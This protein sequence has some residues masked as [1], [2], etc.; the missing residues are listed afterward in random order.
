MKS[1]MIVV[2]VVFAATMFYGLGSIGINQIEKRNTQGLARINGEEINAGKFNQFFSEIVKG[3]EDELTPQAIAFAQN[4]ALNQMIDF[5]L[6]LSEARRRN[7][8]LQDSEISRTVEEI[9]TK[10]KLG[11]E[12]ELDR[13]LRSM[14]SSLDTFK[15]MIREEMLVYKLLSRVRESV[16]LDNNDLREV[17]ARHI[18][19]MV[20]ASAEAK[21]KDEVKVKASKVLALAKAGQ[22]FAKLA[23]TY[24]QDPGSAS[25]GGS[26]GT[27]G[28][29]MM[30]LEFE[31]AAFALR[32][33][34][35]SELVETKYGY[36]IIK[37][38]STKLR[39]S[40]DPSKPLKQALLDDKRETKV[41]ELLDELRKNAKVE[42]EN[43]QLKAFDLRMKGDMKA[44]I[45]T[46]NEAIKD[47]PTDGYL[48]LF[49][50]DTY[51]QQKEMGKAI[52]SYRK[53]VDINAA[54][55][56]F[57]LALGNAYLDGVGTRIG[58]GEVLSQAE[59]RSLAIQNF[60][61]AA[62]VAG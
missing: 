62:T 34:Q 55:P 28:T 27:F 24:S 31:K 37:L 52:V 43:P 51:R 21:I 11:S 50:G 6:L 3:K 59:S 49:L 14:G 39:N 60:R 25:K 45:A 57:L 46:Y 19:F 44:A 33:G 17:E 36:H 9:I 5:S 18:L 29:G 23:A 30:V 40:P 48:E 8:S 7:I 47:N 26:L 13:R 12:A 16:T 35:I 53:A 56:N 61:K 38:E 10:N 1:I 32:P 2:A 41:K 54:D 42:I 58:T 4:M 22:N 20:S 15:D